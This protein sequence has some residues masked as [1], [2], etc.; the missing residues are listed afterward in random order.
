MTF[1]EL[2]VAKS[3]PAGA[4]NRAKCL[5]FGFPLQSW[6]LRPALAL[7][8]VLRFSVIIPKRAELS[9]K[10][11]YDARKG[12]EEAG[13]PPESRGDLAGFVCRKRGVGL[14]PV[15]HL[16]QSVDGITVFSR[17]L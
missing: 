6:F 8:L 2:H 5:P 15:P 9:L 16:Q 17:T 13:K 7:V 12:Q 4:V 14:C 3:Y 11:K 1:V 10:E